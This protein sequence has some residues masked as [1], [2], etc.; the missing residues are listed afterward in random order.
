MYTLKTK[1][2]QSSSNEFVLYGCKS[3]CSVDSRKIYFFAQFIT[4]NYSLMKA[5]YMDFECLMY[6]FEDINRTY[7]SSFDF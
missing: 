2:L 3:M 6:P 1:I 5:K 4:Q 7:R